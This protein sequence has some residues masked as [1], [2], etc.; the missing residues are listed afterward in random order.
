MFI[1]F[2]GIEGSGKTT[3]IQYLVD[4]YSSMARPCVI[5][6]EPGGTAIGNKIRSIL[7]D[8]DSKGMDPTAELLLYMA[9]R[10]QHIEGLIKP[11]LADGKIVV[12]DRYFDA[13]VVYQ[14]GA[15]GLGADFIKKLHAIILANL[16]PD[17]T[18]L[19][20][21]PPET[22]LKRAW[23][24]LN[25]GQRSDEESRFE[26]EKLEFHQQVRAG[27]LELA[28][29]EPE[30]FHIIDAD[31]DEGKVRDSI[32]KIADAISMRSENTSLIK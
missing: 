13:T 27:Y 29:Q 18:I 32:L 10:A 12:C 15:R 9:D 5:T 3:Q 23:K 8:P 14:G 4:Y 28:G 1:T 30:R 24:Q 7:L 22:G 31:Q 25:N 17:V 2:E 21:L 19:L 20:D 16:K 26:E 6:R 11:A